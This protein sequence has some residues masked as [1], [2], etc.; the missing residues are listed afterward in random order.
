MLDYE[1]NVIHKFIN[2]FDIKL[3]SNYPIPPSN[4]KSNKI[5]NTYRT[6]FSLCR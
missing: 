1:Y 6:S 5:I 3:P 2:L 4:T